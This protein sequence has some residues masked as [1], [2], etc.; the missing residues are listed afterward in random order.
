M[1]FH[2]SI[3]KLDMERIEK[4]INALTLGWGFLGGGC[5]AFFFSF[6]FGFFLR[7]VCMIINLH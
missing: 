7:H 3:I 1:Y 6:L 4:K 2:I 5:L